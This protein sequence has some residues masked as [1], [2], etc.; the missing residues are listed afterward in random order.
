MVSQQETSSVQRGFLPSSGSRHPPQ[1]LG[2]DPP[3][4]PALHRSPS[5]TATCVDNLYTSKL[6]LSFLTRYEGKKKGIY[7]SCFLV[8]T[9]EGEGG[10]LST[11]R[12]IAR[13]GEKKRTVPKCS[14]RC[15]GSAGNLMRC[16]W[17]SSLIG[18]GFNFL[19]QSLLN[20][21]RVSGNLS[22]LH[23]LQ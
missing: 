7:T 1:C 15:L 10:L 13:P 12:L 21:Q 4:P 20:H 22:C 23:R 9:V 8:V 16:L 11:L 14:S 3:H 18:P 19:C 2:S 6:Q 17:Q 5:T